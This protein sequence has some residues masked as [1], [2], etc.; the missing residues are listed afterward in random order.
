[1]FTRERGRGS[2]E[3]RR[4][5]DLSVNCSNQRE[6]RKSFDFFR[7]PQILSNKE[8]SRFIRGTIN[9]LNVLPAF[10]LFRI[11]WHWW[12]TVPIQSER[13]SHWKL[14]V[15]SFSLNINGLGALATMQVELPIRIGF[16]SLK[17]KAIE[18]RSNLT[19]KWCWADSAEE[20]A[21][22]RRSRSIRNPIEGL[23]RF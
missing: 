9:K 4:S 21:S 13:E 14:S 6:C 8:R 2:R 11:C 18:G 1:M 15:N 10:K 19:G 23:P 3:V 7:S 16:R 12:Q 20:T 22:L 17:R 5:M